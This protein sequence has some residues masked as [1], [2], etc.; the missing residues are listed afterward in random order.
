VIRAEKGRGQ[1]GEI[2]PV[3]ESG[4]G[5]QADMVPEGGF[6][7]GGEFI[8]LDPG[9]PEAMSEGDEDLEVESAEDEESESGSE[10]DEEREHDGSERPEGHE[11]HDTDEEEDVLQVI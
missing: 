5:I 4:G 8:S 7:D 2:T 11:T 3:S 1:V 10:S 6:E 9:I